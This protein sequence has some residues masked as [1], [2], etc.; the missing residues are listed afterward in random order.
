M[1]AVSACAVDAIPVISMRLNKKPVA[2]IDIIR[3]TLFKDIPLSFTPPGLADLGCGKRF[4]RTQLK[5]FWDSAIHVT[6]DHYICV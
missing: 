4:P 5:V 1:P 6:V 2:V 3:V